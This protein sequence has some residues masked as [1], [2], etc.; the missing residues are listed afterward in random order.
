MTEHNEAVPRER[1]FV[2]GRRCPIC[3][4]ADN[5]SRGYHMRCHGFVSGD[6]N[7][8][9]CAREEKSPGIDRNAA[10]LFAHRLNGACKCGMTHDGT[11]PEISDADVEAARPTYSKVY[12]QYDYVDEKGIKLFRVIRFKDEFRDGKTTKRF[13]Q[14]RWE[15]D[16]LIPGVKGVRQ[17]L[18]RLPDIIDASPDENIYVVEGEKCV[19]VLREA[20]LTATC[21]PGGAGKWRDEYVAPLEGRPVVILPDNDNP[22]KA[23]ADKVALALH[24]HAASI[25]RIELEGLP[26]HGDIADWLEAGHTID[27][28]DAIVE[29]APEQTPPPAAVVPPGT[30]PGPE[31]LVVETPDV[32]PEV[33]IPICADLDTTGLWI[34]FRTPEYKPEFIAMF[35][36]RVPDKHRSWDGKRHIWRVTRGTAWDV[37]ERTLREFYPDSVIDFGPAAQAAQLE[38]MVDELAIGGALSYSVLGLRTDAPACVIHAAYKAIEY[39]WTLPSN[40]R[41]NEQGIHSLRDARKAYVAV[42]K[43]REIDPLPAAPEPSTDPDYA[44]IKGPVVGVPRGEIICMNE[45]GL[46]PTAEANGIEPTEDI[47]I[48]IGANDPGADDLDESD[49]G[50]D[51]TKA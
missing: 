42:C 11:P 28:L 2:D 27:E 6:G 9:H 49:P 38:R 26:E 3:G 4:G 16:K 7:Y 41:L 5:D 32:K 25:K 1:R 33:S 36:G 35:K 45:C 46:R 39:T 12:A 10:G 48:N 8:V 34:G 47:L 31:P 17:V 23:H 15:G 21:N 51:E 30:L 22:G 24:G 14:R 29:D 19:E 50:E 37:T 43:N 18:Y 20:G 40:E 13:T 44:N